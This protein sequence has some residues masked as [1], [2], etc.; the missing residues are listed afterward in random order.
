MKKYI[1]IYICILIIDCLIIDLK[2]Q[3]IEP[4]AEPNRLSEIYARN[5]TIF[6]LG[7]DSFFLTADKGNIWQKIDYKYQYSPNIIKIGSSLFTTNLQGVLKSTDGG[8]TW[9]NANDGLPYTYEPI[10]ETNGI[11]LIVRVSQYQGIEGSV[12]IMDSAKDSWRPITSQLGSISIYSISVND[13]DIYIGTGRGVLLSS[14]KGIS[15]DEINNGLPILPNNYNFIDFIYTYKTNVFVFCDGFYRSTD[16]G[17]TWQVLQPYF[18]PACMM[19]FGKYLY[20]SSNGQGVI[21]SIDEGQTWSSVNDGLVTHYVLSLANDGTDIFAAND[22]AGVCILDTNLTKWHMVSNG[23]PNSNG[24]ESIYSIMAKGDTLFAGTN[25]LGIIHSTDN[26]N[27][28]YFG[29]NEMLSNIIYALI[30]VGGTVFAGTNNGLFLS[31]DNGANWSNI[32]GGL[33]DTSIMGF[34]AYDNYIMTYTKAKGIYLSNDQGNSWI[35]ANNGLTNENV[36]ALIRINSSIFAGTDKGIYESTDNGTNWNSF[37]NELSNKIVNAF[38]INGNYFYAVTES[39][40]F[41]YSTNSGLN[42]TASNGGL[43]S[44]TIRSI[45]TYGDT[46]FIGLKDIGVYFSTGKDFSWKNVYRYGPNATI[47]T[48]AIFDGFLIVGCDGSSIWLAPISEITSIKNEKVQVPNNFFLFQNYPNPFNPSTTI[49]YTVPKK[50]FVTIKVYDILGREVK[51]LINDE[52]PA[53]NYSVNFAANNLASGIYFYTI[54]A[55]SFVQTKKMV[56]LK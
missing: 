19:P 15:W 42:W 21:R 46:T 20:A 10:L 39:D 32:K 49:N 43:P 24:Y 13:S 2:A 23:L 18:I 27:S 6:A 11:D 55:G 30:N 48:L 5:D 12:C 51:T 25:W 22:G 56:L 16:R 28:W 37:N 50:S 26:G 4:N 1:I 29:S 8:I 31:T 41:Y 14:N 54:K 35:P 7:N 38:S 9:Q 47:N 33:P 45:Q 17:L 53:G 40:G 34:L 3:W 52:K 36:H 44:T